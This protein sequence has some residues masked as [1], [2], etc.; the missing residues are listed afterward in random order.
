MII[1]GDSE[2]ASS[3]V[4]LRLRDGEDLGTQTLS[5]VKARVSQAIE[6]KY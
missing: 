1:V 5:Q 6:A 4:S 2:E 3:N